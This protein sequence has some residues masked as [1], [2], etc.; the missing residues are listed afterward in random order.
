MPGVSIEPKSML[1]SYIVNFNVC[2][3]NTQSIN[4]KLIKLK[5]LPNEHAVILRVS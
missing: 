3:I 1:R 5:I 4:K 2:A